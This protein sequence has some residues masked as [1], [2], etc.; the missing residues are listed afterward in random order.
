MSDVARAVCEWLNKS[1]YPLEMA[2]A[3]SLRHAGFGVVQSEYFQDL[4]SGKWRETD[5]I[6]YEEARGKA[7]RAVFALVAECKGGKD[8]PW[9][10]FTSE[11]AYPPGLSVARRATTSAGESI[12]NVLGLRS[13]VT[14]SPLFAVPPRPG[15]GLTLAFRDSEKSDHTHEALDSVCKAAIGFVRR[16][17]AVE[18]ETIIPFGWPAIVIDAPLVEAFLDGSGDLQVHQINEG[19]LIWKNPVVTRHTI[20]PIYT[21]NRF[22][23]LAPT[24]RTGALKF[25]ELVAAENDRH[26]RTVQPKDAG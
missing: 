18:H 24:L 23:E 11:D 17:A 10:L 25:L 3:A 16:L 26:P 19:L 9:I 20:V 2:V 7:C 4:G 1:G 12:L 8:K 22:L 15:H 14:S 6:A 21:R 5:V 13:E